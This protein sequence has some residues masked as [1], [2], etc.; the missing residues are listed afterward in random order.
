M[1]MYKLVVIL[2]I[3]LFSS[4]REAQ[5]ESAICP[6]FADGYHSTVLVVPI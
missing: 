4:Y 1:V 5:I 6:D 2:I 3:T